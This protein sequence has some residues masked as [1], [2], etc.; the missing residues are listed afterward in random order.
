M[1]NI[2]IINVCDDM[3]TGKIAMGFYNDLKEK[4]YNTYFYYGSGSIHTDPHI[5]RIDSVMEYF[6]HTFMSRLTGM[7]G[8]FSVMATRRLI[9]SMN[10]CQ[11]DTIILVSIHGYYLNER[12]FFKHVA[13]NNIR[14]V[15]TMIDEY[16]FLGAC[17]F[18][19]SC[20]KYI[21]GKGK[22]P[23]VRNKYPKSWFFDTC[24]SV[25]R[26][27][28]ESYKAM[29]NTVFCGPEFLVNKASKSYLGQYMKRVVLDEA[30]DLEFY[31]P[32]DVKDLR[33]ELGIEGDKIIILCVASTNNPWKGADFFIEAA[34]RIGEDKRFVFIHIGYRYSDVIELPSNYIPI[35]F[36]EKDSDFA[37]Y[38]SL[39]D[40][41][42]YPSVADAMSNVCLESFA[43]GTPIVCFDI[44]G[45]PYLL[46]ETVGKLVPPRDVD[47]LVKEIKAAKKKTD[48]DVN[49]CRNYALKRYD[50]R[51]N[52]E[53][54]IE[55]AEQTE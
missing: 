40:L 54:L 36:V 14:L 6:Y 49:I 52:I 28:Q 26:R 15:Y 51:V 18:E 10:E 3:S 20:Q 33:K 53:K 2:A 42:V 55:I 48:D 12:M 5:V 8:S 43:C 30:I 11:I 37:R 34:K 25:L 13:K 19:P 9:K 24:S 50:R 16:P 23:N 39:A 21:T 44:S 46:D 1:K 47:A 38:Y 27:K 7:Q 31:K 32:H 22:C 35:K 41:L 17:G 4:G 29:K 45:M